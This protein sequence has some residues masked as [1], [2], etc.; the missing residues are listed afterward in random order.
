MLCSPDLAV[1][2]EQDFIPELSEDEASCDSGRDAHD[3]WDLPQPLQ[4]RVRLTTYL[5]PL[6]HSTKIARQ[7]GNGPFQ[8]RVRLTTYLVPL[9]HSTKFARQN[10]ELSMGARHLSP[11]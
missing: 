9:S 8:P 7:T 2:Q 4:P 1:C 6:S 10:W 5:V 11:A 3:V